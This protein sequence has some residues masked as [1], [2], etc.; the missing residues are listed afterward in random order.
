M[1]AVPQFDA[2]AA[3]EFAV[4][5]SAV[6]AAAVVCPQATFNHPEFG[7]PPADEDIAEP[8]IAFFPAANCERAGAHRQRSGEWIAHTDQ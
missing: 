6:Q 5:R 7:V 1:I 3:G 4:D 2:V 8:E